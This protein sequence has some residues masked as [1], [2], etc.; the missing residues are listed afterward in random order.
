M[1]AVE[2][3]KTKEEI[4]ENINT[5]DG[6][7]K[8]PGFKDYAFGLIKRGTYYVV[9][10]KD[11]ELRFYPSRFIGYKQNNRTAHSQNLK[12]DVLD[13]NK[14]ISEIVGHQPEKSAEL[15]AELKKFCGRLGFTASK[16]GAFGVPRKYWRV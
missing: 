7:L 1:A 11:K 2:L 16:T 3:V 15:E 5:I 8:D 13:T 14:R 10:E 9:F 4:M 12:K 6:Y